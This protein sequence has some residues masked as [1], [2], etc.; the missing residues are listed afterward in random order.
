MKAVKLE[1]QRFPL[2][3]S[4]PPHVLGLMTPQHPQAQRAGTAE[5]PALHTDR[6]KQT[7]KQASIASLPSS[8][9][10]GIWRQCAP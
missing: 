8:L 2:H 9:L 10:G 4:A 6:Q 3:P 7:P 5:Q 1:A